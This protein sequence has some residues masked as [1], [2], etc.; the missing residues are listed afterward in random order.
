RS[1]RL[2]PNAGLR[3]VQLFAWFGGE[4]PMALGMNQ[5]LWVIRA[6]ERHS[7]ASSSS[8]SF[9]VTALGIDFTANSDNAVSRFL[10]E[11]LRM[12]GLAYGTYRQIGEP[13]GL[14]SGREKGWKQR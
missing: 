8:A 1:L 9:A 2:F 13:G 7:L 4:N 14:D 10:E 3:L 5:L 12:P 11:I 6:Y